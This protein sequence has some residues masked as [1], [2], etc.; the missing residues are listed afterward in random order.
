MINTGP[1]VERYPDVACFSSGFGSLIIIETL[2]QSRIVGIATPNVLPVPGG[3]KH[4]ADNGS[5]NI[6]G[7]V[8]VNNSQFTSNTAVSYGGAIDNSGKLTIINS[9]FD[10]NQAYG[11][12]AID[13]GGELTIIKSNFTNNKAT[14]NGGAI[15]NNNI[16]NIVGSVFENNAAGG[17][18][19]AIIA[20]KDINLT[21]SSLF[22][23]NASAGEAIFING[24]DSNV[25]DNWWGDNNPDFEKLLNVGISDDFNWI[26]MSLEST[27]QMMQYEKASV[28]V[29]LNE[30]INKK[31]TVSKLDSPELLPNFKLTII[32]GNDVLIN[33]GDFA[34]SV[35]IPGKNPVVFIVV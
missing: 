28:N 2:S 25:S 34:N 24:K 19:G 14:K 10:K 9:L 23:N 18:G 4:N 31:G 33:N 21:Y 1:T 22:A 11:A 15:D 13:N 26:K 16:L 7:T 12:G 20:R 8:L 3:A 30:L 35:M 5:S 32:G 29:K 17:Q 27:S 6:N